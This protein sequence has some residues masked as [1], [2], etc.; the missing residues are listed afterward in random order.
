[1]A[2]TKN[3]KEISSTLERELPTSGVVRISGL[4]GDELVNRLREQSLS[5]IEIESQKMGTTDYDGFG[6]LLFAPVYGGAFL[7]LLELDFI[8]ELSKTYMGSDPILYTM[9][10]SCVAPN[11]SNYTAK[12]H[13]DNNIRPAGCVRLLIMQILLD[14]FNEENGSPM[15]LKG[16]HKEETEPSNKR[17]DAEAQMIT[18]KKGDV[19]FFDPWIWHRSTKNQSN[20]WRSCVLLGFV[21]PWMKQRFD[22]KPM[23]EATDLSGC[24]DRTMGLL[25]LNNIPPKSW[26]EFYS[27]N[28]PIY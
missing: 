16:S 15:F 22:V 11:Q 9:T 26:D 24:S 19:I 5:S 28:K 20:Q 12:V 23:L 13:R 27:N 4:V 14:D 3:I 17:F 7:E 2:K 8:S 1:M 18:G 21:H 25:G 6:R 10:T